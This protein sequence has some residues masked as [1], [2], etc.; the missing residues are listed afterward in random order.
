MI[1]LEERAQAREQIRVVDS[2]TSEVGIT[3]RKA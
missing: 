3:G 1:L 2:F